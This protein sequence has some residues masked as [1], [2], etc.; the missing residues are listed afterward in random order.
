MQ[1]EFGKRRIA[2]H[3]APSVENLHRLCTGIDLRIQISRNGLR[4]HVQNF[5]QQIGARIHHTFNGAKFLA[6]AAFHHIA[7][8]RKRAAGKT[9]Q[10]HAAIKRAADRSH[11][12]KHIA[13]LHHIGHF[14]FGDIG[15]VLQHPFKFRPLTLGE[16]EAQPHG[17]GHGEDVGKQNRRVQ[18]EAFQRLDGYFRG[19]FGVFAQ[20]EKAARLRA[21]GFVFRQIAAG[22]A[23]HPHRRVFHRLF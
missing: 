23:H 22:L 13:Q 20:I 17:I 8:Q 2:E 12:I 11:R 16:I 9:D 19:Q 7:G 10:R 5:V 6:A 15:L 3:A 1:A 4:I 18:I 21:G 14:Q